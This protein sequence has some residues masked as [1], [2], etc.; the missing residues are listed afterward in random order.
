MDFNTYQSSFTWRYGSKEMRFI[1]SEV[2]KYETWR[3]IWVTLAEVQHNA[4]LVKLK[5]LNDLRKHQQE[6][7][8]NRILD[9]ENETKHDVVAAIREFAEKATIGG[10]KIHLGATSMDIVD[11]TEMMRMK[12][13][14]ELIEEKLM[15]IL[16]LFAE[17]IKQYAQVTC[18]GFTH[19]QPAEPT[20]VGYRLAFYA[21]DLLTNYEFLQFVKKTIKSKGMKGAVGTSASYASVLKNKKMTPEQ[22]DEEVMRRL[23][24]ESALITSQVYSRQYDFLLLNALANISASL[25]KFAADLRILQSPM[26]GEWS[27]PFG[28]RQ[29]GSS[30]MPFKKNPINAEKICSLARYIAHLPQVAL[31]NAMHSYLERTLDDSANRRSIIPDTFLAT[32]EILI[33]AQKLITGLVIN[34]TR[35][36]HNLE[37]FAP[38]AATEGILM[39]AVKRGANRQEMHELLRVIAMEAWTEV[40]IGQENPMTRLLSENKIIS[41]YISAAQ[42][43]KLLDVSFHVGTA[44]KRSLQLAKQLKMLLDKKSYND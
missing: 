21:Q 35:I 26:F 28:K 7:D 24:L 19:L 23:G 30:A 31:E 36:V 13:G 40:Q 25:E 10:G 44:G 6:I 29:V 34:E 3:K 43:K 16:Q 14:I 2:H 39:E 37:Q 4:G 18:I 9:I 11:N 8:I 17:K 12:E 22:M 32:D 1:F 20:T 15:K 38:F 41:Q 5:E 42:L 33:T 27:E